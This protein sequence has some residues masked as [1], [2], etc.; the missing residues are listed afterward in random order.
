MQIFFAIR[1]RY[2]IPLLSFV[3]AFFSGTMKDES[4]LKVKPVLQSVPS[5]QELDIYQTKVPLK[6]IVC[7]L[8]LLEAGRPEDKIECNPIPNLLRFTNGNVHFCFSHVSLVR[9]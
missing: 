2:S 6:D 8:S 5:V 4:G 1:S 3:K 7:Y 9:Y